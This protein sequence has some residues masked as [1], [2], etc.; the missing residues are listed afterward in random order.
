MSPYAG[1]VTGGTQ[2]YLCSLPEKPMILSLEDTSFCGDFS[3]QFAE[4]D[5]L[6]LL[7]VDN[8]LPAEFADSLLT[9]VQANTDFRRSNDYIFA[10][11]KF[12]SPKIES[13]GPHGEGLRHLML[14]REFADALSK[15][16]GK[17]LMVDPDFVG[18][19]LHRGGE[20]SFLDMH[21]DFNLHPK[22]RTWIRELNILLYLNKDWRHQYGGSLDL[23][24]AQTQRAGSVEPVFNRMVLML[25]K[26]H[27]F[28]GYKRI[29][30]P[31]GTYRTSIASYAYSMASSESEIE[32]LR[33]TTTWL[34]EQGGIVKSLVAQATP[35]LVTLKQR[36]FGSA[37][38]RKNKGHP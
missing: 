20:G 9:E 13:L 16:Y 36:L 23:R 5:P 33:T 29:S 30:F 11:N 12:E 35:A 10:K 32:N 19:G 4:G 6:P 34:P 15:M 31:E 14:S 26:N 22:N 1:P 7:I 21:T 2:I 28:H 24:N 17:P 37:T 18:G 27:T 8:F 25:T 3:R 38:A